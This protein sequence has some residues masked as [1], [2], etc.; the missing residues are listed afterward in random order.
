MLYIMFLVSTFM[1]NKV[2]HNRQRN[3]III[4]G[5]VTRLLFYGHLILKHTKLKL[6]KFRPSR[7]IVK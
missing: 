1:V 6:D 2:D 5:H 3:E 4:S 7:S